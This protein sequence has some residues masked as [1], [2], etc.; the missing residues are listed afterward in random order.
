MKLKDYLVGRRVVLYSRLRPDEAALRIN[1]E[2]RSI[3]APLAHGVAG[4]CRVGRVSLHWKLPLIS[5]GFKPTFWGR[6]YEDQRGSRIEA[7]YGAPA[8]LKL[9]Y[10]AW[11]GILLL[12]LLSAIASMAEPQGAAVGTLALPPAILLFAALPLLMHFILN[13]NSEA[14]LGHILAFLEAQA[15]FGTSLPEKRRKRSY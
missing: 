12:I 5:N 14:H 1:A 2:T 6:L 7:R 4:W 10:G 13:R 11:Y 15:Q 9:F 8:H 3:F